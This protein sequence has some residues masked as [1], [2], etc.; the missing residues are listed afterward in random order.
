MSS[1]TEARLPRIGLVG[2][3]AIADFHIEAFRVA[4]AP[5]AAVAST[6]VAEAIDFAKRHD[7]PAVF[8]S[9]EDM[10]A[11]G[12]VDG[13]VV[14]TPTPF[15]AEHTDIALRNGVHVLCEIPIAV[16]TAD[17][18]R[19]AALAAARERVL[20]IAHTQRFWRSIAHMRG[21][22]AAGQVTPIQVI[23][24]YYLPRRTNASWTGRPRR[25]IDSALWHHGLHV[26]DSCLSSAN[27]SPKR[28][29]ASASG[30]GV[31]DGG[32]TDLALLVRTEE[33]VL[34]S[35]T[36]SYSAK[37]YLND[38]MFI[39]EE[40]TFIATINQLTSSTELLVDASNSRA[41]AM[42]V[43]ASLFIDAITG[44]CPPMP[45]VRTVLPAMTV[46]EKAAQQ[47]SSAREGQE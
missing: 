18:Q 21:I 17:A 12:A 6:D 34:V 36:I 2:A 44:A 43:Q 39:C 30:I 5:A 46:I 47:I 23:G 13:V 41:E 4:G 16:S 31:I 40:D 10:L 20:M 14:A 26:I 35:A 3:G 45:T 28:I 42:A 37:T 7:V 24:R 9:I 38:Y 19:L 22:L 27:L 15:H 1:M 33:G 11:R 32:P 29:S 25:W 8:S